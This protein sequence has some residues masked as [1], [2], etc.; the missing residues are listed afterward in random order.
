MRYSSRKLSNYKVITTA[1]NFWR[2]IACSFQVMS[3]N[4]LFL[5]NSIFESRY[6]FKP[7]QGIWAKK[8]T[9]A[10]YVFPP[11]MLR[12]TLTILWRTDFLHGG[13][14][15]PPFAFYTDRKQAWKKLSS[16]DQKPCL[17]KGKSCLIF[18]TFFV[19]FVIVQSLNLP[20]LRM[21]KTQWSYVIA[22]WS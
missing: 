21:Y 1:C 14:N 5:G 4:I 8:F 3:G 6:F 19:L 17:R 16:S 15:G 13:Y 18:S 9:H 2:Q 11:W 10:H 20:S 22:T 7:G 12:R